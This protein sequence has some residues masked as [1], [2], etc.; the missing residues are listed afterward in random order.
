M[1]RARDQELLDQEEEYFNTARE[2]SHEQEADVFDG[3]F[4]EEELSINEP[5]RTEE[6]IPP[7]SLAVILDLITD[8]SHLDDVAPLPLATPRPRRK[9][10]CDSF[11]NN[12]YF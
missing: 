12:S 2:D 11:S 10:V 1:S 4:D 7:N 6:A 5:T 8:T 9:Q 3:L